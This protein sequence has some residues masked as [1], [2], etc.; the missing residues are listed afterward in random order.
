MFEKCLLKSSQLTHTPGPVVGPA[1]FGLLTPIEGVCAGRSGRA[2]ADGASECSEPPARRWVGRSVGVGYGPIGAD[3][4]CRR[5]ADRLDRPDSA[6]SSVPLR[7]RSPRLPRACRSGLRG[8]RLEV[9][10]RRCALA[11]A[12]LAIVALEP[13]V[14]LPGFRAV[15]VARSLR[16]RVP[17]SLVALSYV[18]LA[19]FGRSVKRAVRSL[20]VNQNSL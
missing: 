12:S 6:I 20:L 14:L 15:S 13:A 4:S 18:R 1:A 8:P 10:D 3:S 11:P 16:G 19:A 2:C 5:F 7:S 9:A 17:K